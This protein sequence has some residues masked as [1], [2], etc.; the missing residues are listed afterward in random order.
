MASRQ[1]VDQLGQR[2]A[3]LARGL[4]R[5]QSLLGLAAQRLD[6]LGERLR[7]RSPE[8]SVRQQLERLEARTAA[9]RRAGRRP[10]ACAVAAELGEQA[11]ASGAGADRQPRSSIARPRLEREQAA[12][13]HGI[14]T[15]IDRAQ[16]PPGGQSA[17]LEA[18]SHARVLERGYAIVRGRHDGH[19]IPRLAALGARERTR[20]RLCRR[21]ARGPPRPTAPLGA[22][23]DAGTAGQPAVSGERGIDR[24]LA[25]MRRLRDPEQGLPV[26]HRADLR[27]H[28][29]LHDRGGLRGRRR[30]RA[31]GLGGPPRR[32]G[33][34]VAAGRL[35]HA[36]GRGGRPLRLRRRWQRIADKMIERHPH[37]FGDDRSRAAPAQAAV[38]GPQGGR[39]RGA[40]R[41]DSERARR[42]AGR[43]PGADP[44]AQAA[45]ARRSGRVRLGCRRADPG[46]DRGGDRRAAGRDDTAALSSDERELEL[47]DLL[48]TVVNLARHLGIDP[49]TALR[50]DQRQVRAAIQMD[51]DG[52][53]TEVDRSRNAPL[54][55]S[56]RLWVEAKQVA[57]RER[58]ACRLGLRRKQACAAL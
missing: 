40:A 27:H 45:E 21:R 52:G 10:A 42:R 14:G 58:S 19:V 16:P 44:R 32:A 57:S 7:L 38:G 47:G 37:V 46:Q 49:E 35:L 34:S 25:V 4:P 1:A 56:R 20:H 39:A 26:G 51:G 23:P 29:P 43:L 28:R 3:G 9:A 22:K 17:Q 18:L 48:F 11:G 54:T 30:D 36:D 2:L 15:A 6:D 24:L 5:P 53:I 55:S 8:A 41:H 31:R 12:L 13:G 50:A 33:R